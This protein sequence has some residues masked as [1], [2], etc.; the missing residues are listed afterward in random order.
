MAARPIDYVGQEVVRL[1]TTPAWRDGRLT[2][3][4]FVLRVYAVAT[5]EG[6]RVMPG[7]FC[8]ISSEADARAISMNGAEVADVWVLADAPVERI[9]ADRADARTCASAV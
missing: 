3:A 7:G 1:S 2:A 8:R 9:D 5:P 4:P 6:W